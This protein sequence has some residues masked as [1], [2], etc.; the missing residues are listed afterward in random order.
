MKR[1]PIPVSLTKKDLKKELERAISSTYMNQNRGTCTY[2]TTKCVFDI[3][4][5]YYKVYPNWNIIPEA[6]TDSRKP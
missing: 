1:Q 2:V 5:K 6:L 4:D 3:A